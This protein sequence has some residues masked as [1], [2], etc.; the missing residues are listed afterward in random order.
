MK[1]R[2]RHADKVVGLFV[3]IAAAGLA[4]GI[5]LLGANQRWFSK[6]IPFTTRFLSAAG[7]SPGT[8]IMMRGF[9]IGK[10]TKVSLNAANDVDAKIVIYEDYYPKVRQY[11]LLEIVTSPIGL[12]TQ[13]LFHPGKGDALMT[14][15]SF[16]PLA[17]SE[18]GKDL[19]DRGLVDIPVKD[20]TITRLLAGVNPLIENANKT[21]VSVNR[22]LTEI[23]RALAGQS[24]GPLGSIVSNASDAVAHADATVIN[25]SAQAETLVSHVDS[26]V[27]N[28]SAQAKA[29]VAKADALLDSVQAITKNLEGMTAAMRDPTGLVPRLLDAKGSIKTLLNDNNALYDSISGSVAELEK[30]IKNVQDIS[31]SL[32][33]QMPSIAVTIDEGRTAIKQAQ[34]VLTGLKNN[35]LLKGGIPARTEQLPMSQSLREGSFQ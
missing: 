1:F 26:T 8:A 2:I 9:Q 28:V 18:E 16:L 10:V 30:T 20:D 22:T 6:D 34:D 25:V 7:A 3:L 27:Q 4:A 12:G 17:D 5:V 21:I 11:S 35:P 19:I 15:G 14:P 33:D 31:N 13:L 29:L 24:S 23:N 32:S